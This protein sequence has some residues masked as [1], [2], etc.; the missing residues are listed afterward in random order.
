MSQNI[1]ILPSRA[2]GGWPVKM[3]VVLVGT[4]VVVLIVPSDVVFVVVVVE[5]GAGAVTS[6][7]REKGW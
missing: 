1:H 3:C 2:S 5:R 6:G 4:G 7:G